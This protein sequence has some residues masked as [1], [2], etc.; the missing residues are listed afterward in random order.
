MNTLHVM[1]GIEWE[2]KW[3]SIGKEAETW[4]EFI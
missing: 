1:F 4:K 2:T 3:K